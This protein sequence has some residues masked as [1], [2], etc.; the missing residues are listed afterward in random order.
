[1]I[2]ERIIRDSIPAVVRAETIRRFLNKRT[3]LELL[4]DQ[5]LRLLPI[6]TS[7][8]GHATYNLQGIIG[9]DAVV[10]SEWAIF[11]GWDF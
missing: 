8:I 6:Q 11:A 4:I 3:A 7:I 10:S 2:A 9:L 1:M 5:R